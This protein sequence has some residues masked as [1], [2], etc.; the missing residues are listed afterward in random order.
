M[1]T[2]PV[3]HRAHRGP[4]DNALLIHAIDG[5]LSIVARQTD[6][7]Q[8]AKAGELHLR[9]LRCELTGY[10]TDC[11]FEAVASDLVRP[12]GRVIDLGVRRREARPAGTTD[13]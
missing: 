9:L 13:D 6:D 1:T 8:R 10:C 7:T 5:A 2:C 4:R 11:A 3:C 12:R